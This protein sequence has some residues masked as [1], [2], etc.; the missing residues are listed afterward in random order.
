MTIANTMLMIKIKMLI[1]IAQHSH[2]SGPSPVES[3]ATNSMNQNKTQ[4][5][6]MNP[7]QKSNI[8][9]LRICAF[10]VA[11]P[12]GFN[13]IRQLDRKILLNAARKNV[14]KR[15]SFARSSC[16]RVA[17]S[18]CINQRPR[19]YAGI[20]ITLTHAFHPPLPRFHRR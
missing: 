14:A 1:A 15:A 10:F 16:G 7:H 20:Y 13:A 8:F 19:R 12:K 2:R 9:G 11:P 5:N 18:R 4:K 6:A 3:Q 17:V